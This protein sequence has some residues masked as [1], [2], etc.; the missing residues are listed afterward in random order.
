MSSLQSDET[1]FVCSSPADRF[2]IRSVQL[3]SFSKYEWNPLLQW[4]GILPHADLGKTSL[5]EV[6]TK[7]RNLVDREWDCWYSVLQ[8]VG[9]VPRTR[10]REPSIGIINFCQ[11]EMS[12]LLLCWASGGIRDR[13]IWKIFDLYIL[14]FFRRGRAWRLQQGICL[15]AKLE[16]RTTS[17]LSLFHSLWIRGC[18][19]SRVFHHSLK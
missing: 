17:F 4:I 13:G 15:G 10:G 9:N 5:L 14:I 11:A 1:L 3:M 16:Q 2:G 7:V 6:G 19:P 12:R 8:G 18:L